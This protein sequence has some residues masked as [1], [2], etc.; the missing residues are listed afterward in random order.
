MYFLSKQKTW[1]CSAINFIQF[2]W[3]YTLPT[4]W[5]LL[6]PKGFGI[7]KTAIRLKIDGLWRSTLYHFKTSNF[8]SSQVLYFLEPLRHT[9]LSHLCHSEFCLSCEL[10]L[11]FRMLDVSAGRGTPCHAGN[12]LRALRNAHEAA[13]LGLILPDQ[14]NAQHRNKTN[15]ISLIQ[16]SF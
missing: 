16:V 7:P 11:L 1:K 10:G 3:P 9:I 4:L 6:C 8:C 2:S 12:F 5:V 14:N 15:L 13:A